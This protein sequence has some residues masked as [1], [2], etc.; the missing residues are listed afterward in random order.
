MWE[1][2]KSNGQTIIP[3]FYDV[4]PSDVKHQTSFHQHEKDGVNS[5]TIKTW[6]EVLRQIGRLSGYH[7]EIVNGG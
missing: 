5:N 3:I 6:E 2:R 1:C 4:S 7:R